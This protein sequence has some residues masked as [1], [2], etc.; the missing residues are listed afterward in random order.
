MKKIVFLFAFCSLIVSYFAANSV[1][2]VPMPLQMNSPE[3]LLNPD[4]YPL[5]NGE[6]YWL[7]KSNNL[8]LHAP[9][10]DPGILLP[11]MNWDCDP[12]ILLKPKFMNCDPG[13][14]WNP[15]ALQTQRQIPTFDIY[16]PPALLPNPLVTPFLLPGTDFLRKQQELRDAGKLWL[17][18]GQDL[19]HN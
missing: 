18:D 17:L 11:P 10:S 15:E 14:I 19:F 3:R 4:P 1:A 9:Y 2:Q 16:T 13:I 12:G 8:I 7:G 5:I 6:T